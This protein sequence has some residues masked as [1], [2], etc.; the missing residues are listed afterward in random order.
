MLVRLDSGAP[1]LLLLGKGINVCLAK[2]AG[3]TG[4]GLNPDTL[5]AFCWRLW[6]CR[7]DELKPLAAVL[8]AKL[9]T[10][11]QRSSAVIVADQQEEQTHETFA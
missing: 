2:C 6:S 10:P 11:L 7:A 3:Y 9:K 4:G 1:L 8:G 5:G